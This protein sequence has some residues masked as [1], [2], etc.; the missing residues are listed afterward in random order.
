[1]T[2][3]DIAGTDETGPSDE[4]R[5]RGGRRDFF[6]MAGAT[7]LGA[8]GANLLQ[9]N[10]AAAAGADDTFGG[11]VSF[12]GASSAADA[13]EI[14]DGTNALTVY[15]NSSGVE[16]DSKA[17]QRIRMQAQTRWDSDDDGLVGSG[18]NINHPATVFRQTGENHKGAML[19]IQQWL[20]AGPHKSGIATNHPGVDF[21]VPESKFY[22]VGWICG[23]YDSPNPVDGIHQHMNF[24]TC[25]ADLQN[26]V[27][28][29]QISWGEDVALCSFPNSNVRLGYTGKTV[30]FGSGGQVSASYTDTT[31]RLDFTGHP[32]S[33]APSQLQV[34]GRPVAAT[35]FVRK[36]AD[37]NVTNWAALQQD[38][39]LYL[40]L[41][42]NAVYTLSAFLAFTSHQDADLKLGW[43]APAGATVVWTPDALGTTTTGTIGAPKKS[44]EGTAAVSIGSAGTDVRLAATPTGLVRTGGNGGELRLLWAQNT[45]HPSTSTLYTDSY[46]QLTRVA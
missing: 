38:N 20:E 45:T 19:E 9:A 2:R 44:V 27:T 16:V 36:T 22:A 18:F 12:V 29:F 41:E 32:V 1:M 21:T 11:K 6:R 34:S 28:R 5:G 30:S 23:H 3:S 43:N 10:P 8:A 14:G 15:A 39:H 24:E 7:V 31:E 33:F 17:K 40:T 13:V 37:E 26:K 35:L 46:L 42:P 4:P 25:Q